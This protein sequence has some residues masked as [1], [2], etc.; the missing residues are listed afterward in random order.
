MYALFHHDKQ[1]SK[2]HSTY[3]AALIEAYELHV[4]VQ[5]RYGHFRALA[6]GYKVR[7]LA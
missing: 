1:I 7:K 4:V 5:W 3:A 6:D 2:A